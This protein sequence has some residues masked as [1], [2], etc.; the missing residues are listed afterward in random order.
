MRCD[1]ADAC[2]MQRRARADPCTCTPARRH[3]ATRAPTVGADPHRGSRGASRVRGGPGGPRE[4]QWQA[5]S[6]TFSRGGGGSARGKRRSDLRCRQS[7]ADRRRASPSLRTSGPS[8]SDARAGSCRWATWCQCANRHPS[9]QR[10][11]R[12]CGGGMRWRTAT[13]LSSAAT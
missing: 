12:S 7:A 6:A 2:T 1:A 5:G 4:R 13:F 10:T 9:P 11:F 8:N 3:R